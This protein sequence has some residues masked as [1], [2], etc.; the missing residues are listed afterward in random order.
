MKASYLEWKIGKPGITVMKAIKE[1]FDPNNIMNP[2][3]VFAKS[4]K[5]RLVINHG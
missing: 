1:S 3:K 4:T 5:E 2:G